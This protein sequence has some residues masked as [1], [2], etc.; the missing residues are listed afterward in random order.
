[1]TSEILLFENSGDEFLNRGDE[2]R[3][4]ILNHNYLYYYFYIF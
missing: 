4:S 2:F 1:M 3:T